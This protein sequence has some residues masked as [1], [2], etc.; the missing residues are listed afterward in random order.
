MRPFY[1]QV[2]EQCP[3]VSGLPGDADGP[4]GAAAARIAAAVV[5]DE[6]VSA[7]QAGVLKTLR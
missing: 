4:G 1:A 7:R 3:A 5:E 6:L 2:A